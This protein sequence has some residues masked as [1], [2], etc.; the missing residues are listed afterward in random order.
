MF[1]KTINGGI[2]KTKEDSAMDNNE[3]IPTPKGKIDVVIDTDA[4]N[5]VD[6][7]FAIAYL[8]KSNDKLNT[9]ALYAA[10]FSF[11]GVCDTD[12]GMESSYQEILKILKLCNA[13]KFAYRGSKTYLQN[14]HTPID[15][16]AARDLSRRVMGYT[17]GEPLY[18]L[19]I[20]ALTNIASA[21]LMNPEIV[22]R[23]VVVWLGGHGRELGWTDEFNMRQDLAATRIVMTSGVRLVQIPCE[24]VASTFSISEPEI[25][26]YLIGKNALANYLGNNVLTAQK[27]AAGQKWAR[28]L[29][30][31]TAVGWLLN[32]SDRFMMSRVVPVEIPNDEF[33][34]V[35]AEGDLKERYVFWIN[36]NA[37]MTDL[38][39]KLTK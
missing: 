7:Q 36:R 3:Y 33:M 24:C 12:V 15:S 29:W 9:V 39:D 28:V 27:G 20:G 30:D 34:Y 21:I 32:D 8:L 17:E 31:V 25:K 26:E 4:R 14:T 38:I 2:I 11:P 1:T 35:R 13:T 22:K 23:A 5:E 18:V 10:P 6:D 37:L 19:A 16:E